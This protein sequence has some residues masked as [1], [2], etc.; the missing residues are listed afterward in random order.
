MIRSI[1]RNIPFL[2]TLSVCVLLYV[3]AGSRYEGFFSSRVFLNFLSDNAVLGIAAIGLT[4]VI[5]SGGIDLSVGGMVGVVSIITAILIETRGMPPL[6]AI[7]LVLVLGVLFGAVMGVLIHFYALPPF[8]VTLAGMFL[9]RGLGFMIKLESMPIN[10]LNNL[11]DAITIPVSSEFDL[12]ATAVVFLALLLIALVIAHFT[13]FGRHVYALGGNEQS[14]V[15]MGLPVASTK[16]GVYALSGFCSALAGVVYTFYTS[17][18]NPT[19]GTG[20]ELEAIAAVVIGGSLLSGGIG[21]LAGTLVGVLIFGMI[22]TIITFQGNVNSWWTKIIV[23]LLLLVFILLQK[24]IQSKKFRTR[25][26]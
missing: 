20:L 22:Q 3:I 16:I 12:P 26:A 5:L 18:G 23:G 8:L 10:K 4:F 1:Q 17:S 7:S 6:A 9:A 21:L 15:L 19:A 24:L 14:S 13:P 2:A 25:A 11:V